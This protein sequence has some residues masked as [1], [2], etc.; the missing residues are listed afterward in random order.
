[1]CVLTL[2]DERSR[3]CGRVTLA[4]KRVT[5]KQ[6]LGHIPM[7]AS[8][9]YQQVRVLMTPPGFCNHPL[10]RIA[11]TR[12]LDMAHFIPSSVSG[13]TLILK[14]HCPVLVWAE[15]LRLYISRKAKYP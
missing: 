15:L 6:I 2:P 1:M 9:I 7:S 10:D 14:C 13:G 12:K 4:S 8:A 5:A 11:V 3:F